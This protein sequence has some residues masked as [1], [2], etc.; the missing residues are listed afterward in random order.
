MQADE[1]IRL[2][3]HREGSSLRACERIGVRAESVVD[4]GLS[5][6]SRAPMTFP[7]G[8]ARGNYRSQSVHRRVAT[9]SRLP[10]LACRSCPFPIR[11]HSDGSLTQPHFGGASHG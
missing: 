1:S 3:P 8:S 10:A 6:G 7:L 9:R 11:V 2:P 5:P 4:P